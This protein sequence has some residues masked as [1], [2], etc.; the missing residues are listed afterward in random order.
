MWIYF[1]P[2][3]VPYDKLVVVLFVFLDLFFNFFNFK[4]QKYR[5]ARY[6]PESSEGKYYLCYLLG[7]LLETSL[8]P[9]ACQIVIYKNVLISR[10]FLKLVLLVVM[11]SLLCCL[12][13]KFL[14][15][16]LEIL[17]WLSFI[18]FCFPSLPMLLCYITKYTSLLFLY[19]VFIMLSCLKKR[20]RMCMSMCVCRHL[21]VKES[22]I[23]VMSKLC[24]LFLLCQELVRKFQLRLKKQI[25]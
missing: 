6:K 25:L 20:I 21:F 24:S 19:Y 18:H 1:Y 2:R 5:T 23:W 11:N 22:G 9:L 13:V 16:L 15:K 4:F 3:L 17:S 10:W 12:M 14:F 8:R 7:V